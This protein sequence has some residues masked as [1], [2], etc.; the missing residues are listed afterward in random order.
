MAV[1]DA[2]LF[3]KYDI[4]GRAEGDAAPLTPDAARLIGLAFA[5]HL[6]GIGKTEA[7]IGC[8]NRRTST[9]LMTATADGLAAGGIDVQVIGLT[10]TPAVYWYAMQ[11]AGAGAVMITGSHLPPAQNGLKL[12]VGVRN[13]Y[14]DDLR[15]LYDHIAAD[16]LPTGAGSVMVLD[17]AALRER[18]AADLLMRVWMHRPLKVVIDAGSG[19][20]GLIAPDLFAGWGHEVIP[21]FCDPDPAYPYHQPDP[22]DAANMVALAAA[23]RETGADVGIAFDG[24]ADRMGAV[25]ETGKVIPADRVLTL[26]ALD[27]L[28]RQPGAAIVAD[29]L[30][31]QTFFDAVSAAGGQPVL[32]ASGHSLVKA[33]MTE[34]GALLGGEMSGHIFVG[35]DYYGCDDAY[36]A[37]GRL[38]DLIGRSQGGLSVLAAALPLYYS[39]PEYRP[40]CPDDDKAHVIAAVREVLAAGAGVVSITEIDGVRIQYATGW[41]LLRPSNTEPVLSLRFEGR[42]QEDALTIQSLFFAAL[43]QYPQVTG[44]PT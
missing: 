13:L 27:L 40:H 21:L 19:T 33:K 10:S 37:A 11:Q 1:I 2:R 39:T 34:I 14:G 12:S 15:A 43:R 22:Q 30:T 28:T 44:L 9:A 42:T 35:E 36:L 20:A 41:G 26:L 25:D 32:W 4:R 29:V 38:L 7:V 17:A 24:D 23:V 18:Y 8:D 16:D 31:S 6:R 3:K 5:A